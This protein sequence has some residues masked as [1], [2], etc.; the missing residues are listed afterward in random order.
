MLRSSSRSSSPPR[1][2][3]VEEVAAR[4]DDARATSTSSTRSPRSSTRASSTAR[5][6]DGGQRLSMLETIREYAAERLEERAGAR[7]RGTAGARRLLRGLRA[8]EPGSAVRRRAREHALDELERELGNLLTRLAV[9]GRGRDVEQLKG[10]STACGCS[11]TRRG[12][13]HGAVELGERR[14]SA[15]SP[16]FPRRR[17]SLREEIALRTSLARALLAL[18]GYTEEVDGGVRAAPSRCAKE[19]GELPQQ[20][21]VLRSLATLLHLPRRV[22]R[23]RPRSGRELLRARRATGRRRAPGRRAAHARLEPR[24][25]RRLA[26]RPGAAGAGDRALRSRAAPPRSAS[27]RPEP[28]R[29]RPTR[30]RPCSCGCGA[31]RSAP[32]SARRAPSRSRGELDHPFT[33]AYALFHVGFFDLW[34]R[35]PELVRERARSALEVADEHDYPIWRALG[36]ML[37]GRGG[38]RSA[39]PRRASPDRAAASPLYQGLRTPPVFWPLLLSVRARGLR[40]RRPARGRPAA[41]RRGDRDRGR[42]QPPVPGVRAA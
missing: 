19:T 2:D 32:S 21:P 1:I 22:R 23:R 11:T 40:A 35:E 28:G 7:R 5:H 13:Y 4:L 29:R 3:A 39:A 25:H 15:C 33:L 14:C 42:E 18:H 41:D 34:R 27:A 6:D 30:P 20:F 12:W 24:V 16:P 8:R 9:L 37:R 26:R 10:C 38:G 31:T 36:V 17:S